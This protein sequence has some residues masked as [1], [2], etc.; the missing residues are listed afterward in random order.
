M[1]ES[2][3]QPQRPKYRWMDLSSA[4]RSR[5]AKHPTGHVGL[6]G[7]I[8]ATTVDDADHRRAAAAQ[9]VDGAVGVGCGSALTDGHDQTI[10]HVIVDAEA[11][12]FSCGHGDHRNAG[13]GE[14][15]LKCACN[16]PAGDRSRSL[17]D[18]EDPAQRSALELCEDIGAEPLP[19]PAKP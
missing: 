6:V 9:Q 19:I 17:P 5:E 18:D 8:G 7:E 13:S 12:Q 16:G 15:P 3:I 11:G 2:Q 1:R 4:G 10:A 14:G